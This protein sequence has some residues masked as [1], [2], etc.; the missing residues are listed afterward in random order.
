MFYY[1]NDGSEKFDLIFQKNKIY[2]MKI[3]NCTCKSIN[4]DIYY[5]LSFTRLRLEEFHINFLYYFGCCII[6]PSKEETDLF[7][8]WILSL[9]VISH[10]LIF[11]LW[12]CSIFT[13]N[14]SEKIKENTSWR[15]VPFINYFSL[16]WLFDF[17]ISMNIKINAHG[18]G[19]FTN[20]LSIIILIIYSSN[21]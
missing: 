12:F 11:L 8:W 17:K 7:L 6:P 15:S 1:S 4:I 2:S 9:I 13:F 14:W 16:K 5:K 18:C 19:L 3:I 10:L 21:Y 20:S